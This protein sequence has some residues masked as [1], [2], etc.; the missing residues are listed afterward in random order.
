MRVLVLCATVLLLQ[1][2]P[3]PQTQSCTLGTHTVST[4]VAVTSIGTPSRLFEVTARGFT[5]NAQAR[6]SVHQFPKRDDINVVVNFD[7]GGS[8]R[9]TTDAPL[10]LPTD[11]TFDPNVDVTTTLIE[12]PSNCI[13]T[14]SIKERAFGL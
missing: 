12:S 4:R 6:L 3:L 7:A 13:A 8:L 11:P 14:A 9:W 1:G 10:L 5:P 2:C